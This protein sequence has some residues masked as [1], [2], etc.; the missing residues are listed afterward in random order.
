MPSDFKIKVAQI[1]DTGLHVDT[2]LE[3]EALAIEDKPDFKFSAPIKVA[4]D[5][6]KVDST[7]I[8]STKVAG[9]YLSICDRCLEP[10]EKK[11]GVDFSLDIPVQKTTEFIDLNEEVRQE[12]ILGLPIKILCKEDCKGLCLNCGVDLNKEQCK[13]QK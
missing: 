9:K 12:I 2:Q 3:A 6:N 10:V 4:L 1:Q 8:V 13:C 5:L 7:V 11:W